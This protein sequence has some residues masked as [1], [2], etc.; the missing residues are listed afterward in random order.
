[1]IQNEIGLAKSQRCHAFGDAE[2]KRDDRSSAALTI[3]VGIIGMT[4]SRVRSS[5][6]TAVALWPSWPVPNRAKIT[7]TNPITEP[8][9]TLRRRR[10]AQMLRP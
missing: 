2:E 4:R 6:P 3:S 9:M 10:S 1:M 8:M 7:T 5:L